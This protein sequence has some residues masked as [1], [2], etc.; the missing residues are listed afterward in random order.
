M[1][2]DISGEELQKL[3][4]EID[5]VELRNDEAELARWLELQYSL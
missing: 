4:E 2:N 3:M 1:W 5:A